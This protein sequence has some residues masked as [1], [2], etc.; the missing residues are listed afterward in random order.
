MNKTIC[1]VYNCMWPVCD[2]T[3]QCVCVCVV[4]YATCMGLHMSEA[5]LTCIWWVCLWS[6][7]MECPVTGLIGYKGRGVCVCGG[8]GLVCLSVCVCVSV[9][10]CLCVGLCATVY[11]TVE[12]LGVQPLNVLSACH[13]EWVDV[14]RPPMC[15]LHRCHPKTCPPTSLHSL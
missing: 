15:A 9:W 7:G 2:C 11:G 10:A 5:V 12:E 13:A 4:Y 14:V 6:L 1:A 8:V 3:V